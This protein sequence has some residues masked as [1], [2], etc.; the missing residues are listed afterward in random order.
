[1]A[2]KHKYSLKII[3]PRLLAVVLLA[4][5]IP[6]IQ[7]ESARQKLENRKLDRLIRGLHESDDVML[8][9]VAEKLGRSGNRRAIKALLSAMKNADPSVRSAA[10]NGLGY[11]KDRQAIKA[12]LAALRDE[13]NVQYSAARSLARLRDP[14]AI[15]PLLLLIKD[16]S[17][18]IRSHA[19][20]A[21]RT[22]KGSKVFDALRAAL[23]DAD[24]GVREAAVQA[25]AFSDDPRRI[26]ALYSA[27]RG[28]AMLSSCAAE[29]LALL[30][31]RQGMP[32]LVN[33]VRDPNPKVQYGLSSAL[34]LL[35]ILPTKPESLIE[36]LS[37]TLQNGSTDLRIRAA[38]GL[39]YFG[40]AKIID[41]LI[42]AIK[43]PLPIV[44]AEAM[45]S[46]CKM[47]DDHADAVILLHAKN[48]SS[49][50]HEMAAV[51]VCGNRDPRNI[52][53]ILH[54]LE[55][56]QKN[57][58]WHAA[59]A[60]GELRD[61]R[62]VDALIEALE[63]EHCA[64]REEAARALGKIGDK[65][66]TGALAAHLSECSIKTSVASSLIQLG[67]QP[68]TDRER[69]YLRLAQ[70]NWNEISANWPLSRK[71]LL[72]DLKSGDQTAVE[73]AAYA[74]IAMG[75]EDVLGDLAA[76]LI[77]RGADMMAYLFNNCGHPQLMKAAIQWA[78]NEGRD[79]WEPNMER[80]LLRWGGHNLSGMHC[81]MAE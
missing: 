22:M 37:T 66:A 17:P 59:I 55:A 27:M 56:K 51:T 21:L 30:P 36:A 70:S 34:Y 77:N 62:S 8:V 2:R 74:F 69:T 23:K 10:A 47:H 4:F 13:Q 45:R 53:L 49:D 25:I 48:E 35:S 38:W 58:Q 81:D 32:A 20:Y 63:Y 7:L 15:E 39:G 78:F 41:L 73:N 46:I 11:T 26:D 67:W 29:S 19:F 50:L 42:N 79:Y 40:D 33:A 61:A 68:Q 76:A 43:D 31:D 57:I 54:L 52:S 1:V 3:L 18:I 80:S 71:I 72:N 14:Q 28:D 16:K 75:T 12:L 5:L 9:S 24:D 65:R 44:R 6:V 64:V 60:L